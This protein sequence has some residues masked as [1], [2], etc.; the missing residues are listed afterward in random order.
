MWGETDWTLF[1]LTFI[2]PTENYIQ[3]RGMRTHPKR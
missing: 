2:M 1:D 3:T